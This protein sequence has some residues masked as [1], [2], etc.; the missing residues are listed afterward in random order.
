M[1]FLGYNDHNEYTH[2]AENNISKRSL[3]KRS[4]QLH[5]D[6]DHVFF[7]TLQLGLH[8]IRQKPLGQRVHESHEPSLSHGP[9]RTQ[10]VALPDALS[11]QAAEPR[12]QRTH[13][14]GIAAL[15]PF[16]PHEYL[17]FARPRGVLLQIKAAAPSG[18]K[19]VNVSVKKKYLQEF[20]QST[21][22][23]DR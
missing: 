14:G 21:N 23:F 11:R 19:R 2:P 17:C 10:G 4:T 1:G 20:Y 16:L 7:V 3:V 18:V 22:S 5:G 6:L 9:A 12:S 13:G 8:L 15:D